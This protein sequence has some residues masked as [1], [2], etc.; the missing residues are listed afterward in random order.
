MLKLP[1]GRWTG[2]KGLSSLL[3]P[4]CHIC[5]ASLALGYIPG[6][7]QTAKVVFTPK[8]GKLDYSSAKSYRHICLTSFLLKGLEK[9]VDRYLR[10]GP[11]ASMLIHPRQHAFQAGKSTDPSFLE[12]IKIVMSYGFCA[13]VS[14]SV[15][16]ETAQAVDAGSIEIAKLLLDNGADPNACGRSGKFPLYLAAR[17]QSADSVDILKLLIERRADVNLKYVNGMSYCSHFH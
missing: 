4:I 9:L 3:R 6:A 1:D 7:W 13:L 8:P 15:E 17:N 14:C 16:C 5:R 10:G 12:H 11:L 2:S